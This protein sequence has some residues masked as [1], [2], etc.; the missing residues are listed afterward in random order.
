MYKLYIIFFFYVLNLK[1]VHTKALFIPFSTSN[2]RV[3]VLFNVPISNLSSLDLENCKGRCLPITL[4]H[5]LE[6]IGGKRLSVYISVGV[7]QSE[8]EEPTL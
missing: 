6:I 4:D 2:I 3:Q 1:K 8:I 5:K 7:T